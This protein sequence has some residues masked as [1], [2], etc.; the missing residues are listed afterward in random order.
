[1]E[2]SY[3]DGV[4]R[5]KRNLSFS[6]LCQICNGLNCDIAAVTEVIPHPKDAPK[7]SNKE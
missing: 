6:N 1:V 2:R 3:F 7:Q 4:Q 5:G